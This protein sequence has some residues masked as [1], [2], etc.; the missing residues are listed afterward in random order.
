MSLPPD[1]GSA[2]MSTLTETV[3]EY[4]LSGLEAISSVDPLTDSGCADF[5]RKRL[6]RCERLLV[7]PFRSPSSSSAAI[8]ARKSVLDRL[9]RAMGKLRV[10]L[11]RGGAD[12]MANKF[13]VDVF[14]RGFVNLVGGLRGV[15]ADC[16]F[17]IVFDSSEAKERLC[18]KVR[19]CCR[20]SSPHMTRE[21]INGAVYNKDW[22]GPG[23]P[24]QLGLV[25]RREIVTLGRF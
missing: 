19:T 2:T 25:R 15:S 10:E 23:E 21:A 1:L 22:K 17:P 18:T 8:S 11:R 5:D 9:L 4:R 16:V 6:R 13:E 20:S 24:F 14:V 7:L 12:D 3:L